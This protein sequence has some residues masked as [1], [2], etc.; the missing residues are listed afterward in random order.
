[1]A[2]D[3]FRQYGNQPAPNDGGFSQLVAEVKRMQQTF[4]GNPQEEVQRL[5]EQGIDRIQGY[6]LARPMP[7]AALLEFYRDHPAAAE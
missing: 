3:L 2:H 1:M 4:R 5:T 7:E 6:A